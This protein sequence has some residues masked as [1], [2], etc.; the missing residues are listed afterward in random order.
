MSLRVIFVYSKSRFF[1]RRLIKKNDIHG[2]DIDY[3]A[4]AY[5]TGNLR[6]KKLKLRLLNIKYSPYCFIT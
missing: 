1:A 2:H 6:N 5:F 4:L 3:Y